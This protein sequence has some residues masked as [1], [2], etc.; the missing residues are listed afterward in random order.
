MTRTVYLTKDEVEY[1]I[2][3]EVDRYGNLA[4]E[5]VVI[6]NGIGIQ[7]TENDVD[8]EEFEKTLRD[9]EWEE[10]RSKVENS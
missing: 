3:V 4:I 10:L 8:P 5:Q 6:L 9:H 7:K 1:E 2:E